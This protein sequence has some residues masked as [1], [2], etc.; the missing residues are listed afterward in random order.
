[1]ASAG[2]G[3][4]WRLMNR[5]HKREFCLKWSQSLAVG[6]EQFVERIKAELGP[7]ALGRRVHEVAGGYES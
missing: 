5:C 2:A 1:M 6:S 4:V 3:Q 7:G